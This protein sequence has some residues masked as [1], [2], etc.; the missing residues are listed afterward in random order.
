[1]LSWQGCC[2]DTPLVKHMAG[3]TP[4]TLSI[5]VSIALVVGVPL[6][7]VRLYSILREHVNPIAPI[8]FI[9]CVA[10][11]TAER[12]AQFS[13]D[14]TGPRRLDWPWR[15]C[16]VP[17]VMQA[18]I[19]QHVAAAAEER[20]VARLVVEGIPVFVVPIIGGLATEDA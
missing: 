19:D 9:A 4:S 3:S 13:T 1:M 16:L 12:L 17:K 7:T 8:V 14:D 6:R 15:H 11:T 5:P 18:P 2:T 20:D 10:A